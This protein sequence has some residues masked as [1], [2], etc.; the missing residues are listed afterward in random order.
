[1]GSSGSSIS[2]TWLTP[3]SIRGRRLRARTARKGLR[4]PG[5]CRV[6]P[7]WGH[8]WPSVAT[9]RARPCRVT[10]R[11][12]VG[13]RSAERCRHTSSPLSSVAAAGTHPWP[14]ERACTTI[15]THDLSAWAQRTHKNTLP[16][17]DAAVGT[18]PPRRRVR[19]VYPCHHGLHDGG[20]VVHLH[21]RSEGAS[22][23]WST[24]TH[25]EHRFPLLYELDSR[26][27]DS[28]NSIVANR[29]EGTHHQRMRVRREQRQ[30]PKISDTY[31]L[32]NDK[33][34]IVVVQ[35]PYQPKCRG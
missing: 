25:N 30:E 1:M 15:V 22:L 20:V 12:T 27:I 28:A 5:P 9:A 35:E 31:M 18:L 2:S 13:M 17:R 23:S 24:C 10:P 19:H 6:T 21:C 14:R 26:K 7:P 4:S 16:P 33:C 8:A 34:D 3:T 32:W 11:A 29:E